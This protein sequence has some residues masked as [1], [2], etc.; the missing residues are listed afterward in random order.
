MAETPTPQQVEQKP[1]KLEEK[2]LKFFN[3][4]EEE[5]ET[6]KEDDLEGNDLELRGMGGYQEPKVVRKEKRRIVSR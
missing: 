3:G 4:R 2:F 1:V 6:Y 5:V